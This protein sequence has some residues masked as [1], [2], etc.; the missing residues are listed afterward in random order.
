MFLL[1]WPPCPKLPFLFLFCRLLNLLFCLCLLISSRLF[2]KNKSSSSPSRTLTS[3][4][5]SPISSLPSVNN[6][7]NS[8]AAFSVFRRTCPLESP[9]EKS[10]KH[11]SISPSSLSLSLMSSRVRSLPSLMTKWRQAPELRVEMLKSRII[12]IIKFSNQWCKL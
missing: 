3:R 2:F 8:M 4:V 5:T 11:C 1:L 7:L 9:F 12:E 6:L 10:T